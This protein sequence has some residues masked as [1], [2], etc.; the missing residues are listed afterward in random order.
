MLARC[1][2]PGDAVQARDILSEAQGLFTAFG[3]HA[4]AEKAWVEAQ[5]LEQNPPLT[6]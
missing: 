1:H 2:Q 3:A 5:R 6:A 4:L